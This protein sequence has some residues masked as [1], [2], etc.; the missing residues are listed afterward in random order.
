MVRRR[1]GEKGPRR[2]AAIH[3]SFHA[4]PGGNQD[5]DFDSVRRNSA[6]RHGIRGDGHM[7]DVYNGISPKGDLVLLRKFGKVF[8]NKTFLHINSTREGGGVAEILHRMI[9]ILKGLGIDPRWEVIK[10]D[11]EFYSITK[12]IHNAL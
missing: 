11:G 12:K 2:E 5:A 3:R 9:P 10:G 8:G 6:E 7:I 1:T 4:Q